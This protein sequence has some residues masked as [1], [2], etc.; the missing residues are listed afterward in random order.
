M[1][2][3]EYDNQIPWTDSSYAREYKQ[4]KRFM[5]HDFD[6]PSRDISY[7]ILHNL[8]CAMD[9]PQFCEIGFGQ[10]YDFRKAF[11][12]WHD[13]GEIQYDGIDITPAFVG[14][15]QKDFPMYSFRV[16]GFSDIQTKSRDIMFV[17]HVFEHIA[18]DVFPI[19]FEQF[20]KASRHY[21][22][23]SWAQKPILGGSYRFNKSQNIYFN[24]HN[25]ETVW[26]IIAHTNMHLMGVFSFPHPDN[27]RCMWILCRGA[28]CYL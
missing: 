20:L 19:C 15:A 21:A 26:D 24:A 9:H 28:E 6:D 1:T 23:I 4:W 8:V 5:I 13:R 7:H 25:L 14:F 11:K 2:I 27:V 12:L 22:V 18:K 10:L 16:G 3:N 17:R